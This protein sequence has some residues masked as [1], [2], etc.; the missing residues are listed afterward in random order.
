MHITIMKP[1]LNLKEE[2]R[3]GRRELSSL[4]DGVV[5]GSSRYEHMLRADATAGRLQ[6]H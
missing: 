4:R 6:W 5:S 1:G 3:G 2:L